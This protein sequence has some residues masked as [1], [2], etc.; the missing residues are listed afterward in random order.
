ML[1]MKTQISLKEA[2]ILLLPYFVICLTFIA[3]LEIYASVV[4]HLPNPALGKHRVEMSHDTLKFA[5]QKY[6][7]ALNTPPR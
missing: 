1:K 4:E 7:N 5:D 6:G 3:G 2:A